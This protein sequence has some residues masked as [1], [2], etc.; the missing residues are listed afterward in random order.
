MMAQM[1]AALEKSGLGIDD[2]DY[3]LPHQANI[4]IID[5][6]KKRFG[7]P[8]EKVLTNIDAYGNMSATSIPVLLD[9]NARAGKFRKGDKLLMVAFGAGMT[10]AAA[11]VVWNK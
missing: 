1:E 9:E 10:A 3:I 8:D 5:A 11:V 2:I 4:R 6:A 7:I